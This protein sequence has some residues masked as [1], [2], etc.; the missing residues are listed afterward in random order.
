MRKDNIGRT[1]NE[2]RRNEMRESFRKV[3]NVSIMLLLAALFSGWN[4][5]C[6]AEASDAASVVIDDQD[7]S[8][9]ITKDMFTIS[10][11]R[12]IRWRNYSSSG[13]KNQ[14]LSNN[15]LQYF[16]SKMEQS[17]QIGLHGDLPREIKVTGNFTEI[18]HQDRTL[19][20]NVTGKH[21]ASRLGDFSTVFP[22]DKLVGFSKTIRGVD[23]TYDFGD[24]KVNA[25]MSKQKSKTQ[26]ITFAGQN[27]RGPYN[28]GTFSLVEGAETVRIDGAVIPKSE[29]SINYFRGDIT[30]RY[31]V[32]PTQTV[33]VDYESE[34][35]FELKTGAMNA[36]GL[37]YSPGDK[38]FTIGGSVMNEGANDTAAQTLVLYEIWNAPSAVGPAGNLNTPLALGNSLLEKYN[39]TVTATPVLGGAS[40]TLIRN[41][42]YTIDYEFGT[43]TFLG[44]SANFVTNKNVT[45]NYSYYNPKFV[46]RMEN[47]VL[48]GV[49]QTE[50]FLSKSTVYSG[51]ESGTVKYCA[52]SNNSIDRNNCIDMTPCTLDERETLTGCAPNTDYVILESR[53]S[54]N[55]IN[56]LR[57]PDA[58]HMVTLS[59]LFVQKSE[60]SD[61][62]NQRKIYDAYIKTQITSNLRVEGEFAQSNADISAKYVQVLD[63]FVGIVTSATNRTFGFAT[64]QELV[65]N[66]EEIYF[67]DTQ[68]L[69]NRQYR[70]TDYDMTC[71]STN[72]TITFKPTFVMPPVGTIILANY[73]YKPG[74]VDDTPKTGNAFRG[75]IDFKGERL[76]AKAELTTKD[77]EFAP[78]NNYNNMEKNRLDTSAK[79]K[80]SDEVSVFGDFLSYDTMRDFVSGEKN[81]YDKT[82]FGV[83][84]SDKRFQEVTLSSAGYTAK[85]NIT[86][87]A[88]HKLD[89]KRTVNE[90]KVRYDIRGDKRL[91]LDT[92]FS[93]GDFKDRLGNLGDK[94]MRKNHF[95][96]N[97]NPDEKLNLKTYY[98]T[99][100]VDT[101]I[102]PRVGAATNATYNTKTK[103]TGLDIGYYPDKIWG[104]TGNLL[105][106]DKG[107]SR[108]GFVAESWDS[109]RIALAANPFGR[110]TY[111]D[112]SFYR[113]DLPNQLSISTKTDTVNAGFG[114][115]LAALWLLEPAADVITSE[116]TGNSRSKSD[117]LGFT[118]TF[119]PDRVN[120]FTGSLRYKDNKRRD[121]T[122]TNTSSSKEDQYVATLNYYPNKNLEYLAKYDSRRTSPVESKTDVYTG[123]IKYRLSDRFDTKFNVTRTK[124]TSAMSGNTK[125]EMMLES[126]YLLNKTF[127][128]LCNVRRQ[129]YTVSPSGLE[130]YNGTIVDISLTANF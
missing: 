90:L 93:D 19:T 108:P 11:Y 37:E 120:K 58:S 105:F 92:A 15:G 2:A 66:S 81:E 79:L 13:D 129:R 14:F 1:D 50:Y 86:D 25:V 39:E 123:E 104:L 75:L 12:T 119:D 26:Q 35:L 57:K 114:Y 80:V 41:T 18:P 84:Y 127:S 73:K 103:T 77:P 8:G 85:D 82:A 122:S 22:G 117:G 89:N 106:Q 4:A 67:D 9:T 62:E 43:I 46:R 48:S 99:N 113:Q 17:S 112:A 101:A 88:R 97:Y 87:A 64:G 72:C 53:N 55:I 107:D 102:S 45:V 42:D 126:R 44:T 115:K 28:L 71:N 34:T 60:P 110:F 83:T 38:K 20:L 36:F 33:V 121:E 70:S 68:T 16:N 10:G 63:E 124:N 95:G 52:S 74:S 98:E 5:V 31:N 91:I 29:Y 49:G 100:S 128:L 40:V 59:Y 94:D 118:I 65:P 51:S 56:P 116:V 109:A 69:S 32:D 111:V 78:I 3:L 76:T 6:L 7:E 21:A 96:V 125:N 27:K 30:F 61:Q 130:N 54:I 24:L 47:E 23:F